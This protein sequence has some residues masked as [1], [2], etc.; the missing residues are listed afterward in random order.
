MNGADHVVELAGVDQVLR[1]ILATGDEVDL[2]PEAQICL[3]ADELA[4]V[5]DV[6]DG[7]IAARTGGP[8]SRAPA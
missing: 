2:E 4:V 6:V 5:L 1:A 8:R 3:L 7:V